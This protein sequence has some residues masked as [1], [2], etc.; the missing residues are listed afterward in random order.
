MKK[1][2]PLKIIT[3]ISCLLLAAVLVLIG[4]ARRAEPV[5]VITE[6]TEDDFPTEM[7]TVVHTV[8]E[9]EPESET[10]T[11]TE[12]ETEPEDVTAPVIVGVSDKVVHI[13][14]SVA[15]KQGVEVY[16]DTDPEPTLEINADMVDVST[17][18]EYIVIYIATDASGNVAYDAANVKVVAQES[19]SSDD[20]N[21]L[22]DEILGNIIE[23][24]MSDAQKLDAV[25]WYVYQ[26]GYVDVDYGTVE[27]YLDNAYNFLTRM[28][29]N[30]RCFYAASRLLLERLGYDTMLVRN[31]DD[32]AQTHYWN[33]VSIDGGETWYHFDPT[34]WGWE[35]E[36][37]ICMVSDEWLLSYSQWHS[38]ETYDWEVSKYPSTPEENYDDDFFGD[39]LVF[40]NTGFHDY[41]YGY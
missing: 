8:A 5:S 32:A 11:E 1:I 12:E 34:C 37:E 16:D 6:T 36:Y 21:A 33:L 14:D 19:I 39:R 31:K 13:G 35:E 7:V 28:M 3:L 10:E 17:I 2:S 24:G 40:D 4:C 41:Y 20:A 27:E 22:A 26:L 29:G 9:T 18:G 25:W 30:C 38:M 15:Y 23:E